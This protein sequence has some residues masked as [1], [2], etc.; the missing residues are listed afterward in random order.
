[1]LLVK[2]NVNNN[3]SM[4]YFKL[5]FCRKQVNTKFICIAH[6]TSLL[7]SE[8]SLSVAQQY[9]LTSNL[10]WV[11]ALIAGK[12]QFKFCMYLVPQSPSDLRNQSFKFLD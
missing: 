2:I 1:M 6:S 10:Q 7:W 11:L 9:Y 3:K 5:F 12:L 8:T 4:I